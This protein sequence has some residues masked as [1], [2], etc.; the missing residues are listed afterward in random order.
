MIHVFI[1]NTHFG[2]SLGVS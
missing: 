2:V 1:R